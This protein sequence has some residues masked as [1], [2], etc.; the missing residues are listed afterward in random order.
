V[1]ATIGGGADSLDTAYA[2]ADFGGSSGWSGRVY[3]RDTITLPAGQAI[4]ANLAVLQVRDRAGALVY[5]VYVDGGDRTLRLWSPPGGLAGTAI[6]QS[7]GVA[8]DGSPHRVE[9]SALASDSVIVRVDGVERVRVEHLSGATTGPQRFL[10]AGI[11]HY[12]TAGTSDGVSVEH[13]SLG[14]TTIDWLGDR[15]SAVAGAAPAPRSAAA[16]S[17][18]SPA[19]GG[20]ASTGTRGLD[21]AGGGAV[22]TGGGSATATGKSS[23]RTARPAGRALIRVKKA[24]RVISG[25]RMTVEAVAPAGSVVHIVVRDARWRVI[26]TTRTK[27]GR[28][29]FFFRVVHLGPDWRGQ[30]RLIVDFSAQHGSKKLRARRLSS[31]HAAQAR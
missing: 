8:M 17:A 28:R 31:R 4:G 10:R 24:P 15:S 7:T 25:R 11:D 21:R 1:R 22:P 27:V 6:N 12:D 29:G 3:T 5:E 9:V 20:N 23:A 2:T 14:A 26:T 16:A 19:G 30:R 13:R 18:S